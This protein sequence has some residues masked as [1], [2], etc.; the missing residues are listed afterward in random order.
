MNSDSYCSR[1]A[2]TFM[3]ILVILGGCILSGCGGGS[4]SSTPAAA[5]TISSLS[6]MST[7][8]GGASFTLT[9]NGSNFISGA[10]VTW[11]NSGNPG[12]NVGPVTLVSSSQLTI[13]VS[14]ADIAI[15][16]TVQITVST[17]GGTSNTTTFV[18]DP[19]PAGGAQLVSPGAGGAKPNGGSTEPML[20]F[21]G[22][23][24]VF[25][26]EGTNYISGGT[27]FGQAYARDTCLGADNCTPS[28]L[29]VSAKTGGSPSSPTEGNSLG[30]ASPSVTLQGYLPPNSLPTAGRYFGFLSTATN[31]V[32]PATNW[33]Q[34]YFRDTCFLGS[35][36]TGCTPTTKLVSTTQS[37]IEPNG[38]AS[39]FV[40]A[41][42]T[43]H[44][45]FL[46]R[47]TDLLSGV[48][49][50]NEIYLTICS[51]NGSTVSFT[52]SALVSASSSGV[53]GDQGGEQ[54]AIS[55]DGRFVA[56]VS[57]STNLTSTPNG[58]FL[59]IYLRD[60]CLSAPNG[61]APSTTIVS[62]DSSG[63]ALGGGS[64][65]PAIS[66]DGRFVVFF[67]EL[68]LPVSGL[69][70]VVYRR[71]TCNSSSGPVPG[72]VPFTT[73]ISVA[74]DGSAANGNS[75]SSHHA[76]SGDGRFVAFSS[77]ATNLIAGGNPAG[78]EFVRD[79]C[80]SSSGNVSGCN[81]STN[82]VSASNGSP[83][84]GSGGVI[85]NDGHFVAF[86]NE[87]VAGVFETFLAATGF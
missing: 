2:Y 81:P 59:Q 80:N 38:P 9:V 32:T 70:G 21:N 87:S 64:K 47:G 4:G 18:I 75:S 20:S 10:K 67:T 58:G 3:S 68:S 73:T 79:T 84:G 22:R 11:S 77:D 41:S 7:T 63:N 66:D 61:C 48:T 56:F 6:P 42:N 60:T 35:A 14:S 19:G 15:P 31:L 54:P 65:F 24:V 30:G 62:V 33:A 34:A 36:I 44:G 82:L 74:A 72:C 25:A 40:L 53:P 13:A 83:I 57:S 86:R 12:S 76:I 51:V 1:S 45:A 78:Q 43:C 49:A 46:S 55:A 50:P 29:V 85:S 52:T 17:S 26:S 69:M 37:G 28:T 23:F 39:D 5:P 71:D 8:A 16:C 27:R